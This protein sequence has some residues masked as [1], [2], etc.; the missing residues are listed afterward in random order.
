MILCA[1]LSVLPRTVVAQDGGEAAATGGDAQSGEI[2]VTLSGAYDDNIFATRNNKEDDFITIVSPYLQVQSRGENHGFSFD[3]GA[4]IGIYS[5]NDRENYEDYWGG[6]EAGFDAGSAA[7]IFG[8]ARFSHLHEDRGSPDDAQG[9]Y[10]TV[11]DSSEA[12][13]GFQLRGSTISARFGGTFE[14]L[15]Y[16]DVQSTIGTVNNDDRD[17]DLWSLGARFAYRTSQTLE[18]FV[19]GA[20]NTRRY[21]QTPDDNLQDRDSE[22]YSAALGVRF[23][24]GATVDGEI[25]AGYMGQDYSDPALK[26]VST[27]DFGGIVRWRSSSTTVVSG[28]LDRTI[29]ETTLLDA[30]SY[31]WTSVGANISNRLQRNLT[32]SLDARLGRR[33]FQ[34]INRAD[35]ITDLGMGVAYYFQPRLFIGLD[36]RLI[37]QDSNLSSFDYTE[38]RIFLRLGAKAIQSSQPDAAAALA[39][40]REGSAPDGVY[41]GVQANHNSLVTELFGP[42]G[43]GGT[44]EADFGDHGFGGG[45]F[46]GYGRRFGDWYLGAEAVADSASTDWGHAN[47][48]VGGDPDGRIFSVRRGASYGLEGRIGAAL[49]DGSLLYGLAGVVRTEFETDYSTAGVDVTQEDEM[50]GLRVG[51][52]AEFPLTGGLFGRMEYAFTS[53]ADYDVDVSGVDNFANKENTLRLGLGYR[54]GEPG[55]APETAEK[56]DFVGPYAGLYLGVG[57]LY[58]DNTGAR[59]SG[60]GINRFLTVERADSGAVG[61]G[62]AGIGTTLGPIY[63]GA[64]VSG[65]LSNINMTGDRDPTGRT[66]SV[67]REES[68]GASGRI[69]V[70]VNGSTLIYG[71]AGPVRTRFV[72][73]YSHTT[74]GSTNSVSTKNWLTGLQYGG[75]V[76]MPASAR[77]FVRLDYS[78]TDYDDGYVVDYVSG[79]DSFEQSESTVRLSLGIRY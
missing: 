49:Y 44:L 5:E 73:D 53:Y 45:V 8:G 71:R 38:N 16:E 66:Y 57:T 43:A 35:D 6:F 30:S 21:D 59:V 39:E 28:S 15:D 68:Y 7:E 11:F 31:V 50:T 2:G 32:T 67:Q 63:V 40:T 62:L 14:R 70:V 54:F 60:G 47:V 78:Y 37:N 22:G 13:L 77:T 19:Q 9:L 65:E 27:P 36:Y 51:A 24:G 56:H 4:D 17:R 41:V 20:S 48:G 58:S 55:R 33:D 23:R 12:F 72:T 46:L 76:E 3:V 74:G 69:G 64:E 52:G 75:G 25:H 61:G 34:G 18:F 79:V 26:D 29:E 42:R 10:P 1:V